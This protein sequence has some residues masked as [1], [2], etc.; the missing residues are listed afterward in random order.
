MFEEAF[1]FLWPCPFFPQVGQNIQIFFL[2]AFLDTL[3]THSKKVT[4]L[5]LFLQIFIH[6]QVTV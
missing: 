4:G 1:H 3:H 6:I 5:G 2:D